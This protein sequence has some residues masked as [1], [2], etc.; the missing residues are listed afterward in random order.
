MV[1]QIVESSISVLNNYDLNRYPDHAIHRFKR[2]VVLAVVT[3]N[4]DNKPYAVRKESEKG[5]TPET[6]KTKNSVTTTDSVLTTV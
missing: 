6:K 1:G 5:A 3:P 2:Y 4:P